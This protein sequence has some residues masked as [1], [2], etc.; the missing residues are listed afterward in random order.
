MT[1][2]QWQRIRR[3]FGDLVYEHPQLAEIMLEIVE[4]LEA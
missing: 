3:H 2:E 4:Q 1:D